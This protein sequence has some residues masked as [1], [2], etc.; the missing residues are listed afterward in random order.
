M[1]IIEKLNR[2]KKKFR[3]CWLKMKSISS[4]SHF[5]TSNTHAH[6]MRMCSMHCYRVLVCVHRTKRI[7]RRQCFIIYENITPLLD[8][9]IASYRFTYGSVVAVVGG[10]GSVIFV[11]CCYWNC[12]VMFLACAD[13]GTNNNIPLYHPHSDDYYCILLLFLNL[14]AIPTIFPSLTCFFSYIHLPTES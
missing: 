13:G 4:V 7:E 14:H 11:I 9:N 10:G 5:C 3:R 6:T 8:R 1:I 12:F 2:W